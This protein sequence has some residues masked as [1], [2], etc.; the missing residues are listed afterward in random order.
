MAYQNA[1]ISIRA[2][3]VHVAAFTREHLDNAVAQLE[4]DFVFA[5]KCPVFRHFAPDGFSQDLLI[6][7]HRT[8]APRSNQNEQA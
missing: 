2:N 8:Y 6:D 1:F 7:W 3:R 4:Q 5:H